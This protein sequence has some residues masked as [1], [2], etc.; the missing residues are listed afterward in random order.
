[1]TTRHAYQVFIRADVEEVWQAIIDPAFTSR[2]FF[3]T[4]VESD[5]EPGSGLRYRMA[6]GSIAVEGTIEVFEP[7]YR[8]VH[9]WR[10]LY[11]AALA[12]EPASR[13]EWRVEPAGDGVTRL[14]VLHGDLARSPLTWANVRD[15]WVVVLDSLKSLLESGTALPP[16]T[17]PPNPDDA[18]PQG[19]W[20]RSQAI[21]ANNAT[22]DLL[23][24]EESPQN[25]EDLLRG[26]YAAAYHWQRVGSATPA[27]E[28]RA[29]CLLS[30]AHLRAGLGERA[31]HYADS[32]LAATAEHGL[33]DFD[34]AYAHEARARALAWLGRREEADAALASALS[35]PVADAEDR[36]VV[37]ADLAVPL[38]FG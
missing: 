20:H 36:A 5:F 28:C 27:N 6:D 2:Y 16:V 38:E 18:D 22:W 10:V 9:S 21:E 32:S 31:L 12:D 13:V 8:L 37:A 4:A 1:M 3:G 30:K 34:L 35:V 26:A 24:G 11:D 29:R 25:A 14:R 33:A 15:G 19:D 17:L 7:P 23:D